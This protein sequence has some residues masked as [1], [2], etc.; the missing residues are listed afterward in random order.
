MTMLRRV[1]IS[2]LLLSGAGAA[3]AEATTCVALIHIDDK[4]TI[5]AGNAPM[6]C[7]PGDR[8]VWVVVNDNTKNVQVTFDTFK[9]RP[10]GGDAEPISVPSHGMLVTKDDIDVSKSVRV[11]SSGFGTAQLPWGGFKY[12]IEV[13]EVGGG[14]TN[15]LDPDLDVTPPPSALVKKLGGNGGAPR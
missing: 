13:K 6:L 2:V 15:V 10:N 3:R 4:L 14:R 8:V 5:D 1:C 7:H 11:K 12:R 9:I